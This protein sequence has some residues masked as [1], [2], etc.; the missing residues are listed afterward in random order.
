MDKRSMSRQICTRYKPPPLARQY[1]M[2][3]IGPGFLAVVWFGSTPMSPPP[4]PSASCLSISVLLCVTSKA[5]WQEGGGKR[6]GRS[7]I[8][9]RRESLSLYKSFYTLWLWHCK[10]HFHYI[11]LRPF[12]LVLIFM[13][14]CS[15]SRQICTRSEP[16][17]LAREYWMICRGPGFL[18]VIWFGSTPI[19]PP[20][21]QQ[22][23][24]LSRSYCVSRV[25]LIDRRRG[26]GGGG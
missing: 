7:Q 9:W 26:G 8:I 1:W 2:V 11:F 19:P 16:H 5:Y 12:Y 14:K 4:L 13:A 25:K 15:L 23:I 22:V 10:L 3:N 21:H 24:S 6:W 17:P 20:S 18:A